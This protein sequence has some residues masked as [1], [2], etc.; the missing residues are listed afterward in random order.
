MQGTAGTTAGHVDSPGEFIAIKI[1][2]DSYPRSIQRFIDKNRVQV[3]IMGSFD[4]SVAGILASDQQFFATYQYKGK[5]HKLVDMWGPA[6]STNATNE[7]TPFNAKVGDTIQV[8]I[9][10]RLAATLP[11]SSGVV[12]N[13]G[14]IAISV[15]PIY[16][17]PRRPK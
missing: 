4:A 16:H 2:R 7:P 3:T 11:V 14:G 10:D 5:D 9:F 1:E 6:T 17:Y 12:S 8:R 13:G 15:K